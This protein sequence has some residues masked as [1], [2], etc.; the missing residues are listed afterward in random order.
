MCEGYSPV[1]LL[2]LPAHKSSD[3]TIRDHVF[4]A[5]RKAQR[6]LATQAQREIAQDGC[7]A[8]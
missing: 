6:S 7:Q 1:E 5:Y 4:H 2:S 8:D 3:T